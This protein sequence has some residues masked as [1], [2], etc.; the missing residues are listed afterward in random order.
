MAPGSRGPS[1]TEAQMV[2]LAAGL[3]TLLAQ[4]GTGDLDASAATRHRIE[5]AIAA[6][7]VATGASTAELVELLLGDDL[8]TN[9]PLL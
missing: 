4:L 5:G 2:E 1:L 9:D 7:E 3:R 6:L 8:A